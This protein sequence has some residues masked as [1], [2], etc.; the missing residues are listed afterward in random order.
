MYIV[1]YKVCILTVLLHFALSCLW[2][3][4]YETH[5]ICLGITLRIILD[6]NCTFVCYLGIRG[7]LHNQRSEVVPIINIKIT[8]NPKLYQ[9]QGVVNIFKAIPNQVLSGITDHFEFII[10]RIRSTPWLFLYWLLTSPGHQCLWYWSCRISGALFPMTNSFGCV[11][12]LAV[13]EW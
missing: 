13:E 4:L 5:F 6:L 9:E 10:K 12:H 3:A 2:Y 11:C 1:L 7:F 8:S